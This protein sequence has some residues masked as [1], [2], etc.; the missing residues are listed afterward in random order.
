MCDQRSPTSQTD[1]RADRQTP[2]D[3]NWQYRFIA[4]ALSGKNAKT[5]ALLESFASCVQCVGFWTLDRVD[6][7]VLNN[8]VC[9]HTHTF[10][11]NCLWRFLWLDKL[12]RPL[13]MHKTYAIFCP[14][15]LRQHSFLASYY[16]CCRENAVRAICELC[17]VSLP[18]LAGTTQ[19]TNLISAGHSLHTDVVISYASSQ[20]IVGSW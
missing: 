6:T 15:F 14:V 2:Y 9:L 19:N 16:W 12:E 18:L 17:E 1:G 11:V 3:G 10:L 5:W 13:I 7:K 4:I 8:I 20:W